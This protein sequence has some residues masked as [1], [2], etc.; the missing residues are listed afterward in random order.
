MIVRAQFP[1]K[2]Q[3][4]FWPMRYKVARGGR[5]GAKSW[6]FARTLLS[7]GVERSLR[8]LCARE[9]QNSI[10][11]SV[12]KLLKDQI[13]LMGLGGEYEV[14]E[15]IIKGRNNNT[16]FTFTGLSNQTIYSLKSAEGVDVCWVEE[17]QTIS[18]NSWKIL[19]P[20]IR[21]E[22]SEIWVSYNPELETDPTHQRFTINKPDN[23]VNVEI[24]WRDNPWHND[25]MEKERLHCQQHDPDNYGNIWE[26][27]CKP[28]VEGA[29]YFKEIQAA[30]RNNRVTD[31]PYDPMLKVHV[32]LD[33]GWEDSI[34][35]ALVQKHLSSI[36]IIEYIEV[37]HTTIPAL[38]G[39]LKSR[40]YN[41]GR[42]WL[43]HDGFSASL[44][45]KGKSSYDIFKAQGWNVATRDQITELSVGEGIRQTKLKFPQ[46][47]F[48]RPRVAALKAP[49]S[50]SDDIH[51][52]DLN[53]RLIECVKRY[54]RMINR[55]TD[56]VGLP[57][58]DQFAHGADTL[59]YVAI[60]ADNM[61]NEDEEE[62][63][64]P[65]VS[66]QPLDAQVGM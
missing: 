61:H 25:L 55:Q 60:N 59:R 30:E 58:R 40:R 38:S 62:I 24:N 45:S 21:K 12:H 41:W 7:L 15:T 53:W 51:P 11:D 8:I 43:P 32:V 39:E 35:A 2:L 46:M 31:V 16:E 23:C 54:R 18:D 48:N 44:N 19:I 63:F 33:L 34:G 29:I 57:V 5:N 66:Y 64:I 10:R 28:A 37:N 20:T 36:R 47:Y 1:E 27:Q 56:A 13:E 4:L 49:E 17:G 42:V 3:F 50:Q 9:I 52:T 26:G 6:G 14:M 22:G 65:A